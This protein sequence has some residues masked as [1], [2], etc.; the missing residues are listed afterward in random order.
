M[1]PTPPIKELIH[2]FVETLS[3]E[4]GYSVNTCRAYRNDLDEFA[5]YLAG[6]RQQ[7]SGYDETADDL[8][9]ETITPI[10]IRGYLG[11]L[12]Q[13]NK[14]STIARKLSG[15]RTFFKYLVKYGFI[16]GNPTDLILTPK[17]DKTI[18]AY[19]PVDEMFFLLDSIQT[20]SLLDTRNRAIF[21]SLY[22]T[23]VRVSE[24]AGLDTA[25]VD[26]SAA[27]IRVMGKGARERIVPIG[28][29]ALLAIETYRKILLRQTGISGDQ[30]GPLFL[31]YRQGRLTPRS[32]GRILQKLVS[33]C[34]LYTPA[35]PHTLRHTF[36]THMLDA[37]ADLRVVQEL[38]GHKSLSTTQKYTHVSIDRLMETYDKAHPRK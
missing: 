24:L 5:A 28:K 29:K 3:A 2:S 34:G 27:L 9:M 16:E 32:I 14:K 11:Y 21:E 25:D 17:Q 4:K 20:D 10:I 22:S 6:D 19:L 18:P 1:N 33:D 30:N 37:G 31:N 35:S 38:L 8:R 23:G 13:K 7:V 15:L 12:H 26:I 36:A